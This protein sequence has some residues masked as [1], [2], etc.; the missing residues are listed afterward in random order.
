MRGFDALLSNW[1]VEDVLIHVLWSLA[2]IYAMLTR[3][4]RHGPWR[5][6][7]IQEKLLAGYLAL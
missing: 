6:L 3:C 1:K 7:E 4:R 5:M 2:Q